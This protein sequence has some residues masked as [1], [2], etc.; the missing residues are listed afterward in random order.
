MIYNSAANSVL[1][2]LAVLLYSGSQRH[3]DQRIK[4]K[5]ASGKIM[6]HGQWMYNIRKHACYRGPSSATLL[7]MRITKTVLQV[8]LLSHTQ[9]ANDSSDVLRIDGFKSCDSNVLG[10]K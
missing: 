6:H 2:F 4:K 9:T 10:K 7:S 5:F 1:L 8:W 3:R